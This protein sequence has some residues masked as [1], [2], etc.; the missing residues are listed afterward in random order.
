MSL[1]EKD[2][3]QFE[4]EQHE[5]TLETY[6]ALLMLLDTCHADINRELAEFYRKYG[7]DGVITYAEARKWAGTNDHRKRMVVIFM[8]IAVA[9]GGLFDNMRPVAEKHFRSVIE[10]EF[11]L[12]GVK[13]TEEL[14][15]KILNTKWEHSYGVDTW[16]GRLDGYEDRWTLLLNND[17]KTAFHTKN[18]IDDMVDDYNIRFQSMGRI[19]RKFLIT[20][21]TAVDIL[22][23]REIFKQTGV[24]KYRWYTRMDERV[25]AEC[26]ELHGLTFPMSAYQLGV[27]APPKHEFCRC[28]ILPVN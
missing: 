17:L 13:L 25:C 10:N 3:V 28:F 8:A 5:D 16:D 19:L 9:I 4:E 1:T 22:A 18:D 6:T 27:T 21:T 26:G 14:T 20:E 11:H 2:Y 23:R 7:T 24:K 15:E 12:H